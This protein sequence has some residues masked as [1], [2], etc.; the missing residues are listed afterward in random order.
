MTATTTGR[1][2]VH[3]LRL[4]DRVVEAAADPVYE[5]RKHMWTRH[6]RL[7]KVGKT[8]VFVCLKRGSGRAANP[9]AWSEVL[10]P[11]SRVSTDPLEREIELQLLQKLFK[12]EQVPDDDVLLPTVWL[13]AI[14]LSSRNDGSTSRIR[15]TGPSV[16]SDG[17]E[18]A[19]LWG[20]PFKTRT[21]ADPGG[22][23]A[24]DPV[25]STEAD[26]EKLHRP[27]YAINEAATRSLQARAL[28][29]VD[30]RVPVKIKTDEVGFSPTEVMISLMGMEAVLYA[31]IERP[32]F[33]HR[34]MEL[35]TQGMIAYHL[36][37]EAA[38][39]VDPEETWGYRV[40]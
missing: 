21:T 31:V 24:V 8:P 39:A 37:R 29:L 19:G 33:V 20:L 34:L 28:D 40:Q 23:Y 6:N 17:Q 7:E 32:E 30:G 1:R 27:R 26:L 18:S 11:E 13:R 10:A 2:L 16:D 35:V 25:V 14:P 15:P 12:H 22:A 9:V 3:L 36:E 38:R 5:Q 4:V